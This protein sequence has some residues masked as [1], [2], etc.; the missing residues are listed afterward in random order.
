[1]EKIKSKINQKN[2]QVIFCLNSGVYPLEAIYSTTHSFLDKAYVFLDSNS[3]KEIT[4]FLKG[5]EKLNKKQLN[6][7]QNEFC[8]E[9]LNYLL[10]TEVAKNN[11]K[12]REFV[13]GT[14]LISSLPADLLTQSSLDKTG[15][16]RETAD[17]KSDPL[18]IS[19]PW[20]QKYGKKKNPKPKKKGR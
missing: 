15:K 4:V 5:K 9:L 8:N 19:V 11:Q 2:N 6:R 7:L 18:G 13:V 10:R 17:W 16:T 1:M 3:K 14:A 12:I 20:E